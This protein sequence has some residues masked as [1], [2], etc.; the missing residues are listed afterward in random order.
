[1]VQTGIIAQKAGKK[2][3]DVNPTLGYKISGHFWQNGEV[4]KNKDGGWRMALGCVA[5]PGGWRDGVMF[6]GWHAASE[7]SESCHFD[8]YHRL[9]LRGSL[10][11]DRVDGTLAKHFSIFRRW[12]E[13]VWACRRYLRIRRRICSRSPRRFSTFLRLLSASGGFLFFS[14]RPRSQTRLGIPGFAWLNKISTCREYD[15]L[16]NNLTPRL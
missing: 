2:E 15:L 11:G 13:G 10:V 4:M 7:E 16:R 5:P 6:P 8:S 12:P 9:M 3:K 14:M 1:M